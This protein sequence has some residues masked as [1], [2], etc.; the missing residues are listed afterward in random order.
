MKASL[1]KII[2]LLTVLLF[3]SFFL[4][5]LTASA[6]NKVGITKNIKSL[7]IK[8]AGKTVTIERNQDTNNKLSNSFAKTSRVCPPFCVQPMQIHPEVKTVGEI[9]LLNFLDEEVKQNEG[10]LIDARLPDWFEKGTIPGSINIPFSILDA[11]IES[12]H[13]KRIITLL[14]ASESDDQ[15]DFGNVQS[16]LLF[17]NGPWCGQSAR[18]INNLIKMG[19]PAEKLFWYR[20]GMQS[21]QSLGLTVVTPK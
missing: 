2:K 8:Y 20:G 1:Y 5:P 13:A 11:G 21:W 17:C 7:D 18:A 3:S 19:Y 10:L 14:G 12:G 4:Q 15:W 16:L 9:E 6:E